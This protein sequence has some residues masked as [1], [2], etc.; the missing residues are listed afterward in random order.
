MLFGT[1]TAIARLSV[2][3]AAA[4]A[5]GYWALRPIA[6]APVSARSLELTETARLEVPPG[7]GRVKLWMPRPPTVPWQAAE[8]L[9]VDSPWPYKTVIDPD[10]GNEILLFEAPSPEAGTA[11][12]RIRYSLTR[13]ER[14]G[15]DGRGG[16][17]S[18]LFLEPRGLV[19]LNE[20]IRSIARETTR[21]L[22]DT[23]AKA[24]ALYDHVLGHMQYDTSGEDW[25]RG[26]VAHLCKVGKGN[27]TDFHSLF[28]A[29]AR[30]EGIPA[31][32]RIGYPLPRA[33]DGPVLK[34]YHC[35]AEFHSAG[36]GWIPVDIS[37]A[38]KD[39]PRT[40][41]YFGA[42]DPDRVLVST[43]REI[44][45]P[46]RNGPALNYLVGPH[47][48]IGGKPVGDIDFS[49]SYKNVR[50]GGGI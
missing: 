7:K 23:R 30:A 37:E 15:P 20:E 5:L 46:G 41:Y 11:V 29:L 8:L 36:E 31:R 2:I 10:F 21:G 19:V 16:P 1:R 14:S 17:V 9:G 6:P 22:E 35:W 50:I 13:R 47:A 24:R 18:P 26:D 33:E 40:E 27:C 12:I 4:L 25:G 32:F 44:R 28:I 45:L 3:A 38:W 34:P 42:L 39:P 49:R 48:E 43:G